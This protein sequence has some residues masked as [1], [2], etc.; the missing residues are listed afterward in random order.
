MQPMNINN[1]SSN[2]YYHP[3]RRRY[4]SFKRLEPL[5]WNAN[6]IAYAARQTRVVMGHAL[7]AREQRRA[8]AQ[9]GLGLCQ[10]RQPQLVVQ[11]VLQQV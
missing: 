4:P 1:K 3:K 5:W 8:S 11:A 2:K 10:L 9:R 6:K 7:L